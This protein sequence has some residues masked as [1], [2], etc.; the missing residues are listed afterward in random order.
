MAF[1]SCTRSPGHNNNICVERVADRFL[2]EN[3]QSVGALDRG[4]VV[5]YNLHSENRLITP[6][7][8]YESLTRC[9]QLV[10]GTHFKFVYVLK[11]NDMYSDHR[12]SP[13]FAKPP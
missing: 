7:A 9:Q 1:F 11:D 2:R 5:R 8:V 6:V 13:L 4:I 10:W 3:L 12:N